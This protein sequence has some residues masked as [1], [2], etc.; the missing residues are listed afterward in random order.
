MSLVAKVEGQ[1]LI[2]PRAIA[3]GAFSPLVSDSRGFVANPTGMLGTRDWEFGAVTY[4][5]TAGETNGFVFHGFT[6]SKKF[7]EQNAVAMQFSEGASLEITVPGA[8]ALIGTE[9]TSV[10]SRVT[11]SERFSLGYGYK[12][13]PELSMGANLRFRRNNLRT[14]VSAERYT[15]RQVA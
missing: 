13:T 12:A 9:P 2:S 8:T 3:I 10:D 14:P 11:Y 5:P 7:L 6:I 15:D 4:L 1:S